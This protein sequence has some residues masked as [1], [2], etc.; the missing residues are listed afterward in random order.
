MF[1]CIVQEVELQFGMVGIRFVLLLGVL[2]GVKSCLMCQ[3]F[4]KE[5][6]R[7]KKDSCSSALCFRVGH[8]L[9]S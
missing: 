6:V 3:C 8:H 9:R 1:G 7:L 2:L 5:K 4:I